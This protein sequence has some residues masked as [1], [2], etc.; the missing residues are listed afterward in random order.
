LA[1]L[2]IGACAEIE[3]DD[4]AQ[5]ESRADAEAWEAVRLP[6]GSG[7]TYA[8]YDAQRDDIWLLNYALA[9][10]PRPGEPG[11]ATLARFDPKSHEV[12]SFA[13]RGAVDGLALKGALAVDGEGRV[14]AAWGYRLVRLDPT[15]GKTTEWTIPKLPAADLAGIEDQG[16]AISVAPAPDGRVLGSAGL[17]HGRDGFR[18]GHDRVEQ[19]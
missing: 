8:T 6:L 3:A 7:H 12:Q 17:R 9:D 11:A 18:P 16:L 5:Q 13:I 10:L 2:L 14:W 19:C 15:T 1:A 4:P